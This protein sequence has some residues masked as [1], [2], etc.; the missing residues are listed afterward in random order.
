M[1]ARSAIRRLGLT[2]VLTGMLVLAGGQVPS[3]QP[4]ASEPT[5]ATNTAPR[6]GWV[7]VYLD[8]GD[9]PLAAYQFELTAE[10]G[11]FQIVGIEGGEHPAFAEP[12]YYDPA[13]LRHDRVILAAFS[14][15]DELP[16][17]RTRVARVHVM[18]EG[19]PPQYVVALSVTATADGSL[20]PAT[21]QIEEGAQP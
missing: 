7:D 2:A 8:S 12:P 11:D 4:P 10:T 5:P 17:G 14:T 15:A 6:F 1:N 19:E 3:D 16:A 13:A 20:I 9:V 21:S 18:T